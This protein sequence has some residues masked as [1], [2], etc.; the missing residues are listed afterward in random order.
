MSCGIDGPVLVLGARRV[1]AEEVVSFPILRWPDWSRDE[2][3]G[4]VR[5]DVI[6]DSVN[7]RCAERAF[8]GANA[9]FER[10]WW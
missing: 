3:A 9:R 1:F 4:A 10:V 7:A 2:P 8:I 6:E 5:T